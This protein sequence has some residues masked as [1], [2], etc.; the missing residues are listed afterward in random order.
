MRVGDFFKRM[1]GRK[2]ISSFGEFNSSTVKAEDYAAGLLSVFDSCETEAGR[3]ALAIWR[4]AET[5]LQTEA[6]LRSIFDAHLQY[7]A[8]LDSRVQSDLIVAVIERIPF[9]LEY[10]KN[11]QIHTSCQWVML[12]FD[13]YLHHIDAQTISVILGKT[14]AVANSL[15][16]YCRYNKYYMD[17]DFVTC[18][19]LKKMLQAPGSS[20]AVS[21]SKTSLTILYDLLDRRIEGLRA[22]FKG[23]PWKWESLRVAL[24][25]ALHL[26]ERNSYRAW[27]T[28]Q[29][30]TFASRAKAEII[31]ICGEELAAKIYDKRRHDYQLSTRGSRFTETRAEL[32]TISPE[33]CK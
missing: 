20:S 25:T 5:E 2:L 1:L 18:H 13:R 10:K 24:Q 12:S 23:G 17:Y 31:D 16:R 14:G 29:I 33:K 26:E 27:A 32:R 28:E 4:S 7:V 6:E 11:R 21:V 9:A 19:L 30:S 3:K 8:Q 15:V 22:V